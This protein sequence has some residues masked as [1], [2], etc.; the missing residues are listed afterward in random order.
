MK[1]L[2]LALLLT[3]LSTPLLAA[4]LS[5]FTITAGDGRVVVR[6]ESA[7]E[8]GLMR[9]TL[10]RSVDGSAFATVVNITPR[11]NHQSYQYIDTDL[12]SMDRNPRQLAYRIKFVD[13]NGGTSYSN[14]R[15]TTIIVSSIR[16]TWG[17]IKAMFR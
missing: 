14:T 16:R 1:L 2:R 3:L 13:R 7:D 9:Y 10:E 12:Y 15:E 8:T 6:W 17:S 11:G 5:D 4:S